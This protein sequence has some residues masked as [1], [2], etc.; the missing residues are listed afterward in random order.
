[1]FKQ[2]QEH[3]K[4]ATLQSAKLKGAHE[5]SMSLHFVTP[6]TQMQTLTRMDKV[7]IKDC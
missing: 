2:R 7:V 4:L 6:R 1:M 3:K 5:C